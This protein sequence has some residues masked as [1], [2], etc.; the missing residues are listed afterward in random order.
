MQYL[1]VTTKR[2]LT[3]IKLIGY[4]LIWHSSW[5]LVGILN[6]VDNLCTNLLEHKCIFSACWLKANKNV[7]IWSQTLPE[8]L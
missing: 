6:S 2:K 4:T 8:L 1:Y 5:D 7:V 3:S